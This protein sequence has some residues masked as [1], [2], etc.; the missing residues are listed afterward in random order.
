MSERLVVRTQRLDLVAANEMSLNAELPGHSKL[1]GSLN[2]IVPENWPPDL[3]DQ[4]AMEF[5]LKY[6][7][8]NS[9]VSGWLLWYLLLRDERSNSSVA[10]GII[11]F[12]GKPANDGTVEIGY[13]VLSQYR[14]AGY[15]S[16][17]V[18]AL[19]RWAFGHPEVTRVIGET[20]PNL[21]ASIRVLER[22]GF[23]HIG[24]GS[25]EGVIRYELKRE[26]YESSPQR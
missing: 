13:S 18:S 5:C 14:R 20:F 24:A 23:L 16:E 19:T 21:I 10:V 3:Y 2:A 8:E 17:A 11:G 7:R 26:Q 22:N 6:Y 1:S 4:R 9:D 25:E 15:A 12:K